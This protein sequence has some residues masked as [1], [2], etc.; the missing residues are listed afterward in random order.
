MHPQTIS[1]AEF[2][3]AELDLTVLEKFTPLDTGIGWTGVNV[4]R[5]A[6]PLQDGNP[7]I[8]VYQARPGVFEL[9]Q[10]GRACVDLPPYSEQSEGVL[11]KP[12]DVF[13]VYVGKGGDILLGFPVFQ[14]LAPKPSGSIRGIICGFGFYGIS[15]ISLEEFKT[16][17]PVIIDT[18]VQS[19][20]VEALDQNYT[21]APSSPNYDPIKALIFSISHIV[22]G[23]WVPGMALW[24]KPDEINSLIERNLEQSLHALIIC[25]CLGLNK[26]AVESILE[27]TSGFKNLALRTRH[28]EE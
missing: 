24:G 14:D 11:Y 15:G 10:Y 1:A 22:R 13:P 17:H 6:K 2:G 18:V 8:P 16:M 3:S 27:L 28:W 23:P 5:W 9:D 26:K 12:E 20:W 25:S 7:H 19:L 21:E 4:V